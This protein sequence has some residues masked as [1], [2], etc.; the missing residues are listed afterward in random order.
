MAEEEARLP[1]KAR[2]PGEPTRA[3]WEEHQATHLPFRSWCPHCVAGRQ[4]N[5]PHR[6]Q[7]ERE[8]RVPEVHMDYCFVRRTDEEEV[9]P[10]LI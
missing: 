9:L 10:T 6:R 1:K 4:D 5:P 8:S 2:D 7:E 3:E